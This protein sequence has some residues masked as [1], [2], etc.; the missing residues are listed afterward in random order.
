MP[1][2]AQHFARMRMVDRTAAPSSSQQAA[3]VVLM[4]S[5]GADSTALLVMACTSKLDLRDGRGPARIARER[6]H[7]LHVNH[8]LRGEASDA[9]ERYVRELC[10]RFGVPICVEHA[11][12]SELQGQNLEAAAREVRYAA[13][14]RYVHD[15]CAEIGC[16]RAA[17]RILTAHTASDRTET[18]FMNAI[19]GSG[20]AG[21]SSIPRRR[22]II[23]R[24]LLDMTHEEL[25][26]YLE[27][28]GIP[29]REDETNKDT[30][31]LRNFVRH[32]V[33]PLAA[34][35]NA[36]LERAIGATCD[37]LG[38][39]DAFM[40][41]LAAQALRACLRREREGL[42]V[43]D[44]ARLAS[45]E[46]AIARRIVRLAFRRVAP[47]ER[48]EMRH[49]EA[50]LALVAAHSGSLSLPGGV[51][52]RMEFGTLSLRSAQARESIAAGWLP[53]PG[54]MPLASQAIIE[55]SVVRVPRGTDG[56]AFAREQAHTAPMG[57]GEEGVHVAYVDAAALGYAERDLERL[58]SS[59][60]ELPA[61]V[62]A[63]RLWVD[64]PAPGDIMCP[65][66]MHGRSKKLSDILGAAH[67]PVAERASVP[68]VRTSPG[69]A[70]V[71]VGGIRLD[72]R[73]KCTAASKLLIKLTIR[74][75]AASAGRMDG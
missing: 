14:R 26:R 1:T 32:R 13:A 15:L 12:F 17:A 62:F 56:I 66:G 39:E 3:P 24:P 18:F 45:A 40:S 54:A 63:A 33:V 20:P 64:A 48:L 49:V 31:Y 68:V 47:E 55:S 11:S 57:E 59:E 38:E 72:D 22:N 35:R 52:A 9:D 42:V 65:L 71:W 7:V 60:A 69:G 25:C 41:Q 21:L 73:F 23:V 37:I 74:A 70:V 16:P 19:K 46:I 30:S 50:V 2:V 53:V 27:V 8:H 75:V 5:G 29:W 58:L 36:S 28:A 67:V 6:I 4:V 43:I 44:A 51:D 61:E 34:E 10:E